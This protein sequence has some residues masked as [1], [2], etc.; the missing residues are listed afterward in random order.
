M[1][2]NYFHRLMVEMDLFTKSSHPNQTE[3][4]SS[5]QPNNLFV[6]LFERSFST[7]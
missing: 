1:M 6:L 3:M 7:S 5:L 2:I 4:T